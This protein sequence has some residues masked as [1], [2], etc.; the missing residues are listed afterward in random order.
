MIERK[1]HK[2][3]ERLYECNICGTRYRFES[4]LTKH[5]RES[6]KETETPFKLIHLCDKCDHKFCNETNLKSHKKVFHEYEN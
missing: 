4:S 3:A 5:K 2:Q 6:H 1:A